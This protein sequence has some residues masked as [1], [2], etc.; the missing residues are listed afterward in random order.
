[1]RLARPAAKLCTVDNMKFPER[2]CNNLAGILSELEKF[3]AGRFV[4]VS[5]LFAIFAVQCQLTVALG[6]SMLFS[7]LFWRRK[8]ALG[9]LTL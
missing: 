7:C 9:W 8:V 5:M 1:M 4:I 2:F 6:V 3:L